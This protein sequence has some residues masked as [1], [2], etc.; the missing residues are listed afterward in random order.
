MSRCALLWSIVWTKYRLRTDALAVV[1]VPAQRGGLLFSND[2]S[3]NFSAF[4][5]ATG[6]ILW[7]TWTPT[8]TSNG[9]QPYLVDGFQMVVVA[10]QDTL[11]AFTLNR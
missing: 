7:H 1:A 2:G 6:K 10:A 11:Y 8:L 5:A 9:A 3:S 4:N